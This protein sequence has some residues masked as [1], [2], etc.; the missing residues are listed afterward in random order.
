MSVAEVKR[1]RAAYYGLMSEVDH[2]LGRVLAWLEESGQWQNT[3]IILTCDHGEQLGDHYPS[4]R[5]DISTRR[6]ASQ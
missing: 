3:L 6:F 4:A 5:L 2:N 1:M